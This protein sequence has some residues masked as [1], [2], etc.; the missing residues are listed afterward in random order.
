MHPVSNSRFYL[1]PEI[2]FWSLCPTFL[3]KLALYTL[4]NSGS[5]CVSQPAVLVPRMLLLIFQSILFLSVLIGKNISTAFN[6]ELTLNFAM[7]IS[8]CGKSVTDWLLGSV[9]KCLSCFLKRSLSFFLFTPSSCW[10]ACWLTCQV[11]AKITEKL[12]SLLKLPSQTANEHLSILLLLHKSRFSHFRPKTGRPKLSDIVIKKDI[13]A[14]TFYFPPYLHPIKIFQFY[15]KFN[16]LLRQM[17]K[18]EFGVRTLLA[19]CSFVLIFNVAPKINS[20]LNL[21]QI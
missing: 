13:L 14:L 16:S 10:E 7:Q 9:Q 17:I 19:C 3:Q 18:N 2:L 21:Y 6:V 20:S 5:I 11:K 4:N 1:T 8:I 12:Y 15:E